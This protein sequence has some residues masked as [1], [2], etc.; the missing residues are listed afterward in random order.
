[1]WLNKFIASLVSGSFSPGREQIFSIRPTF[2][3]Q[4]LPSDLN[5]CQELLLHE[6]PGGG[7]KRLILKSVYLS[8]SHIFISPTIIGRGG[9]YIHTQRERAAV[10]C[11][12]CGA[13]DQQIEE[14]VENFR[15]GV[16][17]FL[18]AL[19]FSR[20]ATPDTNQ[21]I[22]HTAGVH[23]ENFAQRRTRCMTH[24]SC[25]RSLVNNALVEYFMTCDP[26]TR[27]NEEI[28]KGLA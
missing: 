12:G 16:R 7:F 21:Y 10:W 9:D 28:S 13:P 25:R 4:L 14:S 26:Q 23:A 11:G 1:M 18:R 6:L 19:S 2:F 27:A 15:S 8:P 17:R 22:T 3:T 5:R 20:S 24:Q